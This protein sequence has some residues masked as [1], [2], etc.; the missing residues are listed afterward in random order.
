MGWLTILLQLLS[1]LPEIIAI[2]LKIIGLIKGIPDKTRR[3]E[4]IKELRVAIKV[5]KKTKDSRPVEAVYAKYK[6]G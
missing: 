1:A 2:V 4:A 5:A 6:N 3:R